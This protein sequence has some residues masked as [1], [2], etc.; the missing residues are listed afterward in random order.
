MSVNREPIIEMAR[1]S[2]AKDHA[3]ILARIDLRIE[4]GEKVAIIGPN[5]SGKS[6]LIKLMM[7]EYRHDPSVEGSFVRIRGTENWDIFEVR[8]A[9][10]LV[11]SDLQVEFRKDMRGLDAVASGA[12]GSIGT[13]RSQKVDEDLRAKAMKA[14]EDVGAAHLS[15]RKVCTLSTGEARRVL[16]ARALVNRPEALILDEPMTSLDLI[17]KG[18]VM[19]A[20]RS[21]ARGGG[22]LVLV[23]HDPSEIFPE[24]ERVIMMKD[25]RIF[26]DGGMDALSQENLT[27]LFDLPVRLRRI[28]GRYLAWS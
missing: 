21:V 19:Q 10:G 18:M 1:A 17:G 22:S 5:G 20:M 14:L 9:F 6:S 3:K 2:V 7:G 27:A 8:K 13:N 28:E 24:V 26:L 4:A 11:S 15:A 23:T 25:G 12:Y 16:M